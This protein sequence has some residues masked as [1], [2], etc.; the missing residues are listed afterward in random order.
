MSCLKR[1]D[2]IGDP[3][4]DR[5]RASL[6]LVRIGLY[7]ALG[8][9]AHLLMAVDLAQRVCQLATQNPLVSRQY[10]MAALC[11]AA[12]AHLRLANV[13]S[14]N[15]VR[16][17]HHRQALE[18]SQESFDIYQSFGFVQIIECVSEEILFRHHQALAANGQ[19]DEAIKYLRRAYDEM[20]RKHAL[21]PADSHFRRTYLENIPLHQ[22]IRA[23]YAARVGL[24]L[25]ESGQM[26]QL[27]GI[28][29]AT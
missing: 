25:T 21:I 19:Q 29:E 10:E 9:E 28:E 6:H 8:D 22:N 17:R 13:A 27:A 24:I 26:E 5:G 11:K 12:T 18:A 16:S 14:N 15:E 1:I 20:T 3:L 23:A 4:Q 7:N 2:E